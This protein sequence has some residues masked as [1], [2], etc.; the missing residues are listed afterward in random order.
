MLLIYSPTTLAEQKRRLFWLK[1]V[2]LVFLSIFSL[3]I[4]TAG[5]VFL[6]KTF[7][8]TVIPN[9][10][11]SHLIFQAQSSPVVILLDK[12]ASENY[13]LFIISS[14]INGPSTSDISS[15]INWLHQQLWCHALVILLYQAHHTS[16]PCLVQLST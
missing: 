7:T 12:F 1:Y 16:M 2:L 5:G 13:S 6:I 4:M 8:Y 15:K 14:V 3:A 10:T 9:V 11:T